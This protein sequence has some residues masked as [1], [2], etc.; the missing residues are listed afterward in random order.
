MTTLAPAHAG[1]ELGTVLGVWAHPDDEAY[2]SA[3]LMA[4][5][6]DAG[7]RVVVVTATAGELGTDDADQLGTAELA[8][9]R[10]RELADSLAALGVREHRFLG[11]ADGACAEVPLEAGADL[12]GAHLDDVRPDTIVTFG[13]EGMTGHPDHRAVHRWVTEAW[14]RAGSPGRLLYATVTPAFHDR[15]GHVNAALDLWQGPAPCTPPEQLALA[16]DCSPML[17]RKLAALRAHASQV[18]PILDRIGLDDFRGW[19]AT[20]SFVAAEDAGGAPT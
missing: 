2:L 9:R 4:A 15:W 16:L 17:D 13:P 14:R 1:V 11:L 3:G 6:R 10:R 7:Q 12:I 18:G 19:W 5:A 20:E 8:Q